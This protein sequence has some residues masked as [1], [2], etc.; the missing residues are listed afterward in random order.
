MSAPPI[1][2]TR[3]TPS[4]AERIASRI[5]ARVISV[6]LPVSTIQVAAPIA[7]EAEAACR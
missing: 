1:G 6:W 3:K 4:T 5:T 7:T 2:I